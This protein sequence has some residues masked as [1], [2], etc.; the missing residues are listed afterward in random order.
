MGR[1]DQG[2][3]I[4]VRMDST[5]DELAEKIYNNPDYF[6]DNER[7]YH[8]MTAA[9]KESRWHDQVCAN[10]TDVVPV[11]GKRLIDVGCATG[12]YLRP[13]REA[14]AEVSGIE[15]STH[16]AAAAQAAIG[17]TVRCGSAHDL[18]FW[19]DG[20]FDLVTTFEM[21]EHVP[22]A[23][24]VAML[25]EFFRVLAPGGLLYMQGQLEVRDYQVPFPEDDVGHIAVFPP[26]YWR[27]LLEHV[28]F[29]LGDPELVQM[30][31][32]LRLKPYW[33]QFK[34]QFLFA[35]KPA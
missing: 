31:E 18:S 9:A 14:G 24:H 10:F 13:L 17:D 11:A 12:V 35:R 27:D 32:D 25:K 2:G 19:E 3:P 28:G 5:P 21:V 6:E 1:F 26:G 8:N 29:R 4:K 33:H 15:L 20:Y 34:W 7:G 30:E 22:Y 16:A 23:Y